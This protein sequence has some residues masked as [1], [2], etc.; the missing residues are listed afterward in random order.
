MNEYY[1]AEPACIASATDFK[2]LLEKFGPETGR[3]LRTYPTEWLSEIE[4]VM[5][6]IGPIAHEKFKT[7]ARRAKE[8]RR[9]IGSSMPY[10]SDDAWVDNVVRELKKV[11]PRIN[12]AIAAQHFNFDKVV[13]FDDFE[14]APTAEERIEGIETE[15]ARVCELLLK[16]SHELV[17]VDP[18]I[19]PCKQD[20]KKVLDRLLKIASGGKAMKITFIARHDEVIGAKRSDKSDVALNLS[21]L[22]DRS[23]LRA[24]CQLVMELY[25]DCQAIEKMHPRYLLSI[26]GGIRLDQGFGRL[27]KSRRVDVSPVSQG[28]HEDLVK[29]YFEGKND[30]S[31]VERIVV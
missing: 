31:L 14:L 7:L 8:K 18:Y 4:K 29:I 19:N 24:D 26:W 3:Y 28:I 16:A 15:Y 11:P 17:F 5:D 6:A 27:P 20:T 23:N 2:H 30:M 21:S 12:Y 9:L 13:A 1:A 10:N 25:D 22:K